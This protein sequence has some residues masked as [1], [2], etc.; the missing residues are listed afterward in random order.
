MSSATLVVS[1]DQTEKE[2]KKDVHDWRVNT[3][4]P[5]PSALFR[6]ELVFSSLYE[7]NSSI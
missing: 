2:E 1:I 5:L 4:L 6:N 7:M 3:N